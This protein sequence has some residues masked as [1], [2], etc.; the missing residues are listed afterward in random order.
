MPTIFPN[1]PVEP[2]PNEN[3]NV[4]GYSFV[5]TNG[6]RRTSLRAIANTV[7][8]IAI[9]P[10]AN[11]TGLQ[12]ALDAKLAKANNLSDVANAAAAFNE[13]KQP[14]SNTVTGVVEL[15]D[16]GESTAGLAVQANDSRLSN[17]RTPTAHAASHAANGSDAVTLSISQVTSLQASLDAKLAKANNLADVANAAAAFDAIKQ[18]ASTSA[19][20]VVQLAPSGNAQAGLVV[21]ANDARLSDN[22]TPNAHAASHAN[23]ASDALNILSL[24]GFLPNNTAFLCANGTFAVPPTGN[25]NGGGGGGNVNAVATLTANQ[26]VLGNGGTD[27]KPLGSHGTAGRALVS[28]GGTLPPVFDLVNL[29]SAV[30]GVANVASGGTG[31]ATLTANALLAGNGTANVREIPPGTSGN[32]L[33]SNGTAWASA[34]QTLRVLGLTLDGAG[35]NIN[36][37]VKGYVRCPFAGTITKWTLL[38][39]N[40]GNV[41][42]DLWRDTYAN[43]PPNV[44]DTITASAKPNLSSSNKAEATTLTGWNTTV[45]AG[46]VFGFNVDSVANITRVI[47]ELEIQ[48]S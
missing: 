32:I 47:L 18:N 15:A 19:T 7:Q 25:G 30:T 46:D 29:A 24:A 16:D 14:A 35:A 11:V 45:L 43:F 12:A 1:L 4:A 17:S 22:R 39:T 2:A 27:V 34:A 9:V 26:V 10:L 37:G 41:V 38:S 3:F 42:V 31:N 40:I 13:I 23:G 48:P 6:D 28:A 33:K 21:Q 20:G 44:S 36:T 5:G 8:N